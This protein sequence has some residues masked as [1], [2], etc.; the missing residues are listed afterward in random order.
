MSNQHQMQ[1]PFDNPPP[2]GFWGRMNKLLEQAYYWHWPTHNRLQYH[3]M[4]PF[5]IQQIKQHGTVGILDAYLSKQGG[6]D[7]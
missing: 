4:H 2:K 1:L 7:E 6:S 5:L 3:N